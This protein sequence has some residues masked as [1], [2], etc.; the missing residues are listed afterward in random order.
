[1]DTS[2]KLKIVND[3]FLSIVSLACPRGQTSHCLRH[4]RVPKRAL[5]ST[6]Q[7]FNGVSAK[8]LVAHYSYVPE[9]NDFLCIVDV[10]GFV[11]YSSLFFSLNPSP[12]RSVSFRKRL[13]PS[14]FSVHLIPLPSR[15]IQ[16]GKCMFFCS[17]L[18]FPRLISLK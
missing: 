15:F 14:R 1:M 2:G 9:K 7:R 5:V 12:V 4:E 6:C 16:S 10:D 13:S 18:S 11:S 8:R 17:T 3:L